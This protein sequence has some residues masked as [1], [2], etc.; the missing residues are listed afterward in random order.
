MKKISEVNNKGHI[1]WPMR[2]VC[3]FACPNKLDKQLSSE[4][5]AE[6]LVPA[7]SVGTNRNKKFCFDEKEMTN[8]IQ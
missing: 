4:T 3:T 5:L 6:N 2:E 1:S 7:K 8:H